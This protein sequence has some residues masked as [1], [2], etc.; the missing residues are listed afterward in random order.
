MS[1]FIGFCDS[2]MNKAQVFNAIKDRVEVNVAYI[3]KVIIICSDRIE[4]VQVS[5]IKECMKWLQFKD[6]KEKFSFI[7]NKSDRLTEMEKMTNLAY[8]CDELDA[9]LTTR[10]EEK[11]SGLTYQTK[12]NQALGF[13]RDAKYEEVKIDLKN[14]M[15]IILAD[16]M[17]NKR[18]CL[19]KKSS[20]TIL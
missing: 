13:K 19:D 6:Y 10:F 5:A 4:G 9:D 15:A 14:L 2:K 3:D 20:C 16:T 11:R 1:L 12:L 17:P 7:Y 8:M 18:I